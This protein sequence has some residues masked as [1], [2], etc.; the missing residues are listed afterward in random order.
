MLVIT[1]KRMAII[2]KTEMTSRMHHTYSMRQTNRI[3]SGEPVFRAAEGYKIEQLEKDLDKS[4]N[5]IEI[6]FRQIMDI[7]SEDK[8]WGTLLKVKINMGEKVTTYR[9]SV[10]KGWVKYPAKDP[11]QF[12]KMDWSP[13]VNLVKTSA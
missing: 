2:T 11:I 6:P 12:Q 8:R 10:V 13:L 7:F 5:N 4:P 3:E 9:F 1:D